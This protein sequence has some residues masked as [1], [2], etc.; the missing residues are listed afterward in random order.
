MGIKIKN[1]AGTVLIRPAE[2]EDNLSRRF[3]RDILRNGS[4]RYVSHT[5]RIVATVSEFA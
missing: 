5:G 3:R 2:F 1:P 4:R